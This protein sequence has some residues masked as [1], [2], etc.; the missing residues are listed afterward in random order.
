MKTH[1]A[2]LPLLASLLAFACATPPGPPSYVATTLQPTRGNT[3]AGTVWFIADGADVRIR[4][5]VSGLTPNQEHGFHVHEKGDCSSG[6]GMSAGGHF[7]PTGKPHG[8]PAGEH[9]AGDLPA[10]TADAAGTVAIDSRV[11]A[12]ADGPSGFAGK[13]LIVHVNPDD[14]TTQPTGNSGARIACGVIN[15]AAPRD[16]SGQL[17]PLPRDL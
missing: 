7:N 6:D 5:R 16:A 3:A 4:G 14:Y 10:L 9:H 17:M 15:A 11:R 12:V 1:P 2:A 8:P 13:A